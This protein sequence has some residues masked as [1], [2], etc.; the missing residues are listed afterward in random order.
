[1]FLPK[2]ACSGN[3]DV[4]NRKKAFE[5]AQAIGFISAWLIDVKN[6]IRAAKE[7]LVSSVCATSF[8]GAGSGRSFHFCRRIISSTEQQIYAPCLDYNIQC[9]WLYQDNTPRFF[10]QPGHFT[11]NH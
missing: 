3:P 4:E 10:A 7:L 1:M 11:V 8:V 2:T 6:C 5:S 9:N